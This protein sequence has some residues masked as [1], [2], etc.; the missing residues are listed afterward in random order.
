[1]YPHLVALKVMFVAE[2]V[3]TDGATKTTLSCVCAHVRATHH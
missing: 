1:M 3:A 2:A